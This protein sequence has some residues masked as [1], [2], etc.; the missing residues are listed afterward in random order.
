MLYTYIMLLQ[1]SSCPDMSPHNFPRGLLFPHSFPNNNCSSVCLSGNY[2]T[3]TVKYSSGR[4]FTRM[5]GRRSQSLPMCWKIF[6]CRMLISSYLTFQIS[7]C[8]ASSYFIKI[9]LL[10]CFNIKSNCTQIVGFT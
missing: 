4:H 1:H 5:T 10:C 6:G 8:S 9:S 2:S 3:A 7:N